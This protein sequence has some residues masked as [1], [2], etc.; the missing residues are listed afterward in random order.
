[1][2]TL[3]KILKEKYF[4]FE[5]P[6][7]T[8]NN[9][10]KWVWERGRGIYSSKGKLLYLEGFITDITNRKSYESEIQKNQERM[11]LL[12]EEHLIYSFM[13]R[14]WTVWLNTFHHL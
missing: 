2:E 6:I 5:Y 4:E 9:I 14:T 12:V 3:A 13:F 7:I 8:K 11:Q 10:T 1:M